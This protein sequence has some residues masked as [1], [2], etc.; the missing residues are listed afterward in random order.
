MAYKQ[1]NKL[2][3]PDLKNIILE[4]L[5]PDVDI[6]RLRKKY[7]LECLKIYFSLKNDLILYGL[8][9]SSLNINYPLTLNKHLIVI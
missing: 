8:Y 1:L 5:Y 7:V 3:I 2:F 9:P 4:Y 6:I